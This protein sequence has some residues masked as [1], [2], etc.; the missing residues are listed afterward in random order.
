MHI[1]MGATMPIGCAIYH[2]LSALWDSKTV[3]IH[4]RG[5]TYK[6]PWGVQ[7]AT[8]A[9]GGMVRR[10]LGMAGRAS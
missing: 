3:Q 2:C 10:L 1:L 9:G 6:R 4:L 5:K 7:Q 8:T